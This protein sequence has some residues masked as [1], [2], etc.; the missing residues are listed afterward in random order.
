M[1]SV[2]SEAI[3]VGT[4][5]V[6]LAGSEC[7]QSDGADAGWGE[8]RKTTQCMVDVGWEREERGWVRAEKKQ[9][10]GHCGN[11]P[12]ALVASG[13]H[14]GPNHSLLPHGFNPPGSNLF[15]QSFSWTTVIWS[16]CLLAAKFTKPLSTSFL[17]PEKHNKI[18]SIFQNPS[19]HNTLFLAPKRGRF[20]PEIEVSSLCFSPGAFKVHPAVLL[21]TLSL[22]TP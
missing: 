16:E 18:K 14:G 10:N 19:S 12:V 9:K 6:Q 5:P 15:P 11:A 8:E 4:E 1:R 13:L 20:C 17:S 22:L 2:R 3:L 21:Q 7:S